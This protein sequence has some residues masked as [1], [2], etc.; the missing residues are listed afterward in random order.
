M[1]RAA[2]K[3]SLQLGVRESFGS[4]KMQTQSLLSA[5]MGGQ[6]KGESVG[7]IAA[8]SIYFAWSTAG[9]VKILGKS[10]IKYHCSR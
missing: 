2:L 10:E 5:E 7:A 4:K 3:K 8:T 9:R 6:L 1:Q